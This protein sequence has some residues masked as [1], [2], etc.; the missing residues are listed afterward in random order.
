MRNVFLLAINTLKITFRKKG[1]AIIYLMM[2]IVGVIISLMIYQNTSSGPLS[3]SVINNDKGILS[4]DMVNAMKK[5]GNFRFI[6]IEENEIN[7]ALLNGRMAAAVIIPEG[8]SD[9]SFGKKFPAID[10]IS[11]KG[12]E[13]TVW[14]ESF[15]NLYCKNLFD[16]A[17]A[18]GESEEAFNKMY[19]SFTKKG[20][21]V[22][23]EKLPDQAKNMLITMQSLGFL[24]MFMM[25]ATN[26]T[27]EMILREKRER[28]YFRIRSAPVSSKAYVL[29][30]VIANIAVVFVQVLLV[31]IIMTK[32]F[33]VSTF[34]PDMVMISVLI[35]FGMVAIGIG[36]IIVAFS[37][38]SYQSGTLS[39]LIMVPTCMLGGCFWSVDMM[40]EIM[41]KISYFMPQ[42]WALDAIN[43]AQ[44]GGSLAGISMHLAVLLAFACVFFAIAAYKLGRDS[45]I[46]KFV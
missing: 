24:I 10:I 35:C 28:T 13:T 39:I 12:H 5:S 40:P 22:T 4:Q 33:K 45:S 15:I 18:S 19:E 44:K 43:N 1:N 3:I 46:R 34:V 8:F 37:G 36:M 6:N 26:L 20:L 27:T 23:V 2:P 16:M 41:R 17:E 14:V 25:L 32:V 9:A 31:I 11:V 29:G 7:D 42:R 30:N 21:S 38:S